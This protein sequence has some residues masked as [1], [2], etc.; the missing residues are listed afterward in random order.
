MAAYDLTTSSDVKSYL[1]ITASTW[2]T[3]LANLVTNCSVWIENYCGG[4]RF[5]NSGVDVT[6]YHDGDPN[7]EGKKIIF[8]RNTPIIS[9]TSV[10]YASGSLSSPTWTA[11]DAA[12][13]YVRNDRGGQLIF[14]SLPQG[15][16]NIRVIYQGGYSTIPED[17]ALAC[18]QLIARVF[19][20]R[21]SE[22]VLNESVGGASVSWDRELTPELRKTINRYRSHA[23]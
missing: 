6:E 11:F 23:V 16:Q 7:L 15:N 10:S 4:K 8:V 21:K 5:K 17:L 14:D 1:D 12:S 18:I 3:L 20:K 9:V 2:D 22:G 13:Y 19:N